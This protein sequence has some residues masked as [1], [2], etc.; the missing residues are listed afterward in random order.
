MIEENQFV[1]T[2]EKNIDDH[3]FLAVY[4]AKQIDRRQK[5]NFNISQDE[6]NNIDSSFESLQV[7]ISVKRGLKNITA[8][9]NNQSTKKRENVSKTRNT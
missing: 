9:A 4:N 2:I 3:S 7:R 8:A 6:K 5:I 1:F